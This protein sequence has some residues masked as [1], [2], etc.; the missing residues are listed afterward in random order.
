[1]VDQL[2]ALGLTDKDEGCMDLGPVAIRGILSDIPLSHKATPDIVNRVSAQIVKA[3]SS[4]SVETSFVT[5][6]VDNLVLIFTRFSHLVAPNTT[7]Q[8]SSLNLFTH[9]LESPRPL[10]RKKVINAICA[11]VP[12]APNALFT[13]L[14]QKTNQGL[15]VGGMAANNEGD[16]DDDVQMEDLPKYATS[17]VLLVG[18][19]A[20][21]VPTKLHQFL[22]ALLERIITL[23]HDVEN[24]EL[25]EATMTTLE[26]LIRRC[27]TEVTP[28][29]TKITDRAID[30]VSYDPN[31]AGG[32]GEDDGEEDDEMEDEDDEFDDEFDNAYSD[33]EDVS[34]KARRSSAKVLQA[35]IG[36]RPELL[37]D[38]LRNLAP[39]LTRRLS[40]REESVRAEVFTA[41]EMLLKQ[42]QVY[43]GSVSMGEAPMGLKRKRTASGVSLEEV[44]EWVSLHSFFK[45][46]QF[47]DEKKKKSRLLL[48]QL[49][50]I[51]IPNPYPLH[52]STQTIPE[53]VSDD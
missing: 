6:L 4:S 13:N 31:Y 5:E 18:G 50:P 36:S 45:M 53:Q 21:S 51:A 34:W 52:R 29:L 12:I 2:L 3:A 33:D 16:D 35:L 37:N 23:S 40:E 32:L 26:T 1:M 28:F 41:W 24:E 30:L 27:P 47:A 11:L 7:L 20:E 9:L 14:M 38:F 43:G 8:Q 10:A 17:Y 42:V 15:G 48:S 44:I 22:P 49:P 39:L 19:L 25:L 46:V